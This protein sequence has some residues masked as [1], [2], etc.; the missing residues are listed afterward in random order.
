[1]TRERALDAVDVLND[2]IGDFITSER[3]FRYF[4]GRLQRG[5]FSQESFVALQRMCISYIALAFAKVEEFWEHYHDIIPPDC[6]DECKKV[7]KEI[8]ERKIKNFRNRCVGHI[9][10]SKAKRPLRHSEVIAGIEQMSKS[11]FHGFLKWVNDPRG[12]AYPNT[13]V[14]IVETVRDKLA[15]KYGIR[16]EEV[17]SR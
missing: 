7:L 17:T 2:F 5:E 14:S 9:W 12:N 16:P 3:A 1:M 15:E 4:A 10:D 13:V 8:R 6:R 11:D